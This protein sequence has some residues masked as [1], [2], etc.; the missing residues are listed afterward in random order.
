MEYMLAGIRAAIDETKL[1]VFAP[2]V[3][4]ELHTYKFFLC[5]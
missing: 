5:M 3:S 1:A 4:G 2:D